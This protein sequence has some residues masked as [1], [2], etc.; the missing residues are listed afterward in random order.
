[1]AQVKVTIMYDYGGDYDTNAEAIKEETEAWTEGTVCVPDILAAGGDDGK[2]TVEIIGDL[3]S[4]A[5]DEASAEAD[6]D[7]EDD[8]DDVEDVENDEDDDEDDEDEKA[9]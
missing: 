4:E 2:L 3:A 7:D 5:A 1:M 6:E 9:A 8:V